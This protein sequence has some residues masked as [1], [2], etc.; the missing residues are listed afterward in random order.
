MLISTV[1]STERQQ[2]PELSQRIDF[3]MMVTFFAFFL[4][5][6]DLKLISL[7]Y[8]AFSTLII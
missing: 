8:G 1:D 7:H 5:L 4:G 3:Q 2:S 6:M